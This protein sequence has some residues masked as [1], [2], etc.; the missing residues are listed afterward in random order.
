MT[1]QYPR[2]GS[3]DRATTA[4]GLSSRIK[5]MY[6]SVT[7]MWL[8]QS[9]MVAA[10]KKVWTALLPHDVVY[11]E[12]YYEEAVEGAASS[13]A[14]PIARA[15]AEDLRPRTVLDVGCGSGALLESLKSLGVEAR[16]L[17]RSR[18][19]LAICRAKGVEVAR[20]D[21]EAD[22]LSDPG[23]YDVVVSLE[24]AEHLPERVAD[25]YVG[26]LCRAAPVVVI[27]A[28]PPGQGGTDHVN[29]QPR[30]Y[31]VGKFGRL[32]FRLQPGLEERWREDWEREGVVSWYW[33]NL[34]V[35]RSEDASGKGDPM[36]RT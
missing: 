20:F 4:I 7:P 1:T 16:G 13:A 36:V 35:F 12:D 11:D 9:R 2:D 23:A 19:A 26:L 32:G 30:E 17:E 6:R 29:E 33:R 18:A 3:S 10:L 8:R 31:W 15:I 34:M 22:E 5:R 21:L 28:A 14:P 24:V 27:T 25:R